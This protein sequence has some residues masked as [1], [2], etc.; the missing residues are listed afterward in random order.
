[1]VSVLSLRLVSIITSSFLN[2]SIHKLT[3]VLHL[4]QMLFLN[5]QDTQKLRGYIFMF[6]AGL[7]YMILEIKIDV[8]SE[9]LNVT[10]D[11]VS[12]ALN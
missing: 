4:Y 6:C 2:A 10:A 1:M 9:A 11:V 12:T 3:K 5:L 8:Y 7:L